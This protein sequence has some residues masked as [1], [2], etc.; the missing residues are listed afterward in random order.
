MVWGCKKPTPDIRETAG[1]ISLI[2][3]LGMLVDCRTH[4]S[5]VVAAL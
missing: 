1:I 4:P 2:V 5:I 3:R